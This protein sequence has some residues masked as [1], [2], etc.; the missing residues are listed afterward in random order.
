VI[1]R[2]SVLDGIA[3]G[4]ITFAFRR[5]RRPTV[6]TGGTLMTAIGQLEIRRVDPV[7]ADRITPDDAARAGYASRDELL[8]DLDLLPE[9]A[10]STLAG[11]T[12]CYRIELGALRP[13]P[14]A[15]LRQTPIDDE[16]ELDRLRARLRKLA[17]TRPASRPTFASSRRSA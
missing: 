12:T 11:A 13:D 10:R 6:R 4:T 5:W 7:E 8:Q 3:A 15:L 1:L 14:R 16:A 9:G 17:A 2:R